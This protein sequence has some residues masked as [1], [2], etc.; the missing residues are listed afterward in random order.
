MACV[1][2]LN[3]ISVDCSTSMGGLKMVYIANY[4]D[5]T[6]TTIASGEVT[7]IAMGSGAKF[8]KY[9]FRR[10]TA[11]MTSTLNVDVTNGS[12]VSTEVV[13]SFLKQETAKRI[14]I[15]ALSSFM[16]FSYLAI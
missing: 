7:N 14:E 3:G 11:S 4:S 13:L 5:V 1:Q 16:S 6:G 12:T 9:Y 10:N 15:S 8:H 2:T